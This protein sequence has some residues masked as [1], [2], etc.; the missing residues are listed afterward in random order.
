MSLIGANGRQE[1]GVD[2]GID[3][4]IS[5]IAI[6]AACGFS[7]LLF[8]FPSQMN[9]FMTDAFWAITTDFGF[10][11]EA[12]MVIAIVICI[13][14]VF[15]PLKNKRFGNSTPEGSSLLITPILLRRSTCRCYTVPRLADTCQCGNR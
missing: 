8:V 9:G 14:L 10:L 2:R 12:A 11:W 6:V 13:W 15:G 5:A 4:L 3:K 7:I 1:D